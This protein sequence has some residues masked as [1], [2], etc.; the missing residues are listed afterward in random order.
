MPRPTF[1]DLIAVAGLTALAMATADR[2]T[3][4]LAIVLI[5]AIAVRRACV[6]PGTD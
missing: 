2:L 6:A 5:V 3:D 4:V 1:R